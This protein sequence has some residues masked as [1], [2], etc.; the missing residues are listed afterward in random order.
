[1]NLIYGCH[2]VSQKRED[3][4]FSLNLVFV[5]K[6]VFSRKSIEIRKMEEKCFLSPSI[7]I[8]SG[9]QDDSQ[10]LSLIFFI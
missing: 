4:F 9:K 2:L 5:S 1:M 7:K 3:S 10:K 6:I 8:F